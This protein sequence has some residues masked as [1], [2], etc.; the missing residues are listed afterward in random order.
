M[1]TPPVSGKALAAGTNPPASATA[2]TAG[3]NPPT[4]ATALAAGP[5]PPASATASTAGPNPATSHTAD[6]PFA[7][8]ITFTTYGA[9]LPGDH[10]GWRNWKR[11]QRAAEP[12]L[13]DWCRDRMSEESVL[14]D[15]SQREAV[16]A[17]IEEHA[18]LR[19]WELHAVSVRT[20]HVHLVVAAAAPPKVV[21]DQIKANATRVLRALSPPIV[22]EKVWTKGGDIEFIDTEDEL[23]RVVL[24]VMEAQDRM[25]RGKS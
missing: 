17:V 19:G 15:R 25:D 20:N 21:R 1:T 11:G 23:E 24:Y 10:R 18:R 3:P 12:L 6:F 7:L 13:E 8:F 9:W 14:L 4:S 5:N 2:S 16:T 22:N